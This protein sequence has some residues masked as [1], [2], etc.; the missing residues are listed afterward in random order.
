MNVVISKLCDSRSRYKF[1]AIYILC[2][3]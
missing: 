1:A 3:V 2:A